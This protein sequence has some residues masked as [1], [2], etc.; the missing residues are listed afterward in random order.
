[1]YEWRIYQNFGPQK[2][3]SIY[4]TYQ[5]EMHHTIF[6]S[7]CG[8]QAVVSVQLSWLIVIPILS[9]QRLLLLPHP[10]LSNPLHFQHRLHLEKGGWDRKRNNTLTHCTVHCNLYY[11]HTCKYTKYTEYT[12]TLYNCLNSAKYPYCIIHNVHV[13]IHPCCFI[14]I[15]IMSELERSR[16]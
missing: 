8:L 3:Y 11:K 10:L 2:F 6:A 12:C 13:C 5:C 15:I 16:Q 9:G 4:S 7:Q 1:M 14:L